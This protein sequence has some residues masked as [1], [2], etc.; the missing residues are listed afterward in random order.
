MMTRG[1]VTWKRSAAEI[2]VLGSFLRTADTLSSELGNE[3]YDRVVT[4]AWNE[5]APE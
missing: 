2:E 3:K 1:E 4:A 5:I